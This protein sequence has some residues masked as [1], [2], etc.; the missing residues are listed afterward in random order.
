MPA[1]AAS[2]LLWPSLLIGRGYGARDIESAYRLPV[3]FDPRQTV[4]VVDAC[5]TPGLARNLAVYRKQ[6]GL[7]ACPLVPGHDRAADHPEPL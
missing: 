3:T 2:G 5:S 7:P 1:D 6:N 4:A